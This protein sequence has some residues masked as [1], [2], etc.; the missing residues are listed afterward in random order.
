MCSGVDPAANASALRSHVDEAAEGGA[1]ILFTPEMTGLLDRN[2]SRA[3]LHIRQEADDV[4][5]QEARDSA[6]RRSIWLAIGSLA[7]KLDDDDG[8][9]WINRSYLISPSGQIAAK[10]DKIHLFDVDLDTGETWRES[11]AYQA[12]TKAVT[13]PVSDAT[14]GLSICYDLRFPS[15]FASLTNAG[16]DILSIPAAF[17][18]PTGKAHWE[19]LL[20]A[21]AIEAGVFV[22]AAAQSGKHEDGR[23]TYGHSMVVGPWGDVLLD[24]GSDIGVGLCD[25]D[26][27]DIAK[28]QGRIPAISNRRAFAPPKVSS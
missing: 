14:L 3:S 9:K 4:V 18:V 5:L 23:E 17:T 8:S 7:I 26:L 2:R 15:L 1:E 19:I 27:A 28:I 24:M 11:A 25:I 6:A 20:R 16:A 10:Y 13:S 12:G 21:R 22:V